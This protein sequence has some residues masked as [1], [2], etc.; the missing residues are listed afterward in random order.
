[1][2]K[3]QEGAVIGA[4]TG[5]AVGGVVGNQTGS[6]ARGA[7]IGAVVGG[8]AGAIIGHQM[9][10]QAK[11]LSQAIPGATVARVG[12]GIEV[13]FAS[14]LLFAF[15]SDQILPT[16]GTNLTELAKS[17]NKYPDSQLLIVGHTDN[18][19]DASYNQRL[20]ER[21]SNSA[22]AYLA[23]QG[24]A[25]T[26][27]AASGK[28]E[29]EPVATNDTDAGRQ[30]NRRVEVAIYASEAYRQRLLKSNTGE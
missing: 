10:Q 2:N 7:I 6:T 20:S 23:A 30:L 13:T 4:A 5:A 1:M 26:R 8:A 21:R 12:E 9:D 17:L 29:S 19:G 16:A 22:A 15:D 25:R 24:V 3:Q 14:G 18:V 28:G 11:E 27:L